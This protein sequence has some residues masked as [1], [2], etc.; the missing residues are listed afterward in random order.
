MTNLVYKKQELLPGVPGR[1][2]FF[3]AGGGAVSDCCCSWLDIARGFMLLE[4]IFIM[5]A[6]SLLPI[7]VILIASS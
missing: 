2:R 1:L 4:T 3:F 6:A 5:A 7:L